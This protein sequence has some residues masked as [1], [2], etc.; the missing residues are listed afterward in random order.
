MTLEH[1]IIVGEVMASGIVSISQGTK[2]Q[3]KATV[4]SVKPPR[5][6]DPTKSI[7]NYRSFME[8]FRD[9][10]QNEVKDRNSKTTIPHPWFG[11]MT[12]HQWHCLAG[13]HQGI[14]RKQIQEII[15]DL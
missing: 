8:N 13:L 4:A 12:A 3:V 1:L 11:E 5:D 9:K 6:Q 2:P 7:D 15:K 10:M 14:H